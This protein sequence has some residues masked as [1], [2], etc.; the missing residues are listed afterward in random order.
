MTEVCAAPVNIWD[1]ST[2]GRGRANTPAVCTHPVWQW[3]SV[4]WP[5]CHAA[6]RGWLS[7]PAV[8]VWRP[9]AA[10]DAERFC[11]VWETKELVALNK[12]LITFLKNKVGL[13]QHMGLCARGVYACPSQLHFCMV[14]EA[15]ACC[16]F[17]CTMALHLLGS[18][19]GRLSLSGNPWWCHASCKMR[20]HGV[21]AAVR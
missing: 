4:C 21:H 12:T 8:N 9:L 6:S 1:T 11:L 14:A 17:Q 19:S 20:L 5:Q 3:S 13:E 10:A 16:M 18:Q 7:L 2:W 15:L